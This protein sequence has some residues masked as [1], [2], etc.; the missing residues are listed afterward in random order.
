MIIIIIVLAWTTGGQG[1]V[2]HVVLYFYGFWADRRQPVLRGVLYFNGFPA[3]Q[4]QENPNVF[5]A[6]AATTFSPV[7]SAAPAA[8]IFFTCLEIKIK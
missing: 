7:F 2:Q 4:R 3:R 6:P 1:C 8:E 5:A